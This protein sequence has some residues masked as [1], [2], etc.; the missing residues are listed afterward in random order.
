MFVKTRILG[1]TEVVECLEWIAK[2]F[3]YSDFNCYIGDSR[4]LIYASAFSTSEI[5]RIIKFLKTQNGCITL[6]SSNK[7]ILLLFKLTWGGTC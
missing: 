5:H 1:K 7:E 2:N 4:E 6:Y 3:R